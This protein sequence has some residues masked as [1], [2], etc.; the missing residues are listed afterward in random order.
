MIISQIRNHYTTSLNVVI[1]PV[2]LS[3]TTFTHFQKEK[4]N[5]SWVLTPHWKMC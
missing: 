3:L 5:E 4:R 1:T 2:L